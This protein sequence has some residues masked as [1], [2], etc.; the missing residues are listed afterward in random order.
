MSQGIVQLNA[1]QGQSC[2]K[3]IFVLEPVTGGRE[4][5]F[6]NWVFKVPNIIHFC[7]M[8]ALSVGWPKYRA[9]YNYMK[10]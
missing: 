4:G 1:D 7:C 5:V 2:I 6:V 3:S 10:H 8:I 9:M